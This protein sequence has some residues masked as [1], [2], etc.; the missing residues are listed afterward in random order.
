MDDDFGRLDDVHVHLHSHLEEEEFR[1]GLQAV[2]FED[3][4]IVGVIDTHPQVGIHARREVAHDN[5]VLRYARDGDDALTLETVAVYLAVLGVFY[6]LV[7][8]ILVV[9]VPRFPAHD[10]AQ[11]R[12]LADLLGAFLPH[13][14]EG[15]LDRST[16]LELCRTGDDALA[17]CD[18]LGIGGVHVVD[19]ALDDPVEVFLLAGSDLHG[20]GGSRDACGGR[21]ALGRGPDGI[22][23]ELVFLVHQKAQHRGLQL[24]VELAEDEVA[25]R[26]REFP[27]RLEVARIEFEVNH[28]LGGFEM[29]F[30]ELVFVLA[31]FAFGSVRALGRGHV[32]LNDVS[33]PDGRQGVLVL[34]AGLDVYQP[35]TVGVVALRR[36][37]EQVLQYLS[38]I[39]VL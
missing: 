21:T 16:V 36:V 6:H 12:P 27:V 23:D 32:V 13:R 24:G 15:R 17:A 9:G 14:V 5:G 10:D 2:H 11:A 39:A 31:V 20:T 26:L 19:D 29:A 18:G 34:D 35:L 28:E 3:F 38:G 4:G 22:A 33:Q 7:G 30:R 1:V 8:D 25:R 37:G